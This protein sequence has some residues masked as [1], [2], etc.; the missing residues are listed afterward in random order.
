[1]AAMC[2]VFTLPQSPAINSPWMA[3][4]PWSGGRY[5]GNGEDSEVRDA[6][7][8]K[9]DMRGIHAVSMPIPSHRL[10]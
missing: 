10:N 2:A 5:E 1:M 7:A 8:G 3:T 6:Q 9:D 4:I